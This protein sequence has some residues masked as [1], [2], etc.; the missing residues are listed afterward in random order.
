MCAAI[1][2]LAA[3]IY[4]GHSGLATNGYWLMKLGS[5]QKH[6]G[7]NR[8]SE[9][10]ISSPQASMHGWLRHREYQCGINAS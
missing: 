5:R 10:S 7:G 3:C 1:N 4:V 9:E 6:F 8:R 2:E